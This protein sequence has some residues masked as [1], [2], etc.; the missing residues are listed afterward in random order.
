MPMCKCLCL[1]PP[2][3]EAA[4]G[5]GVFCVG[6]PQV[7]RGTCLLLCFTAVLWYGGKLWGLHSLHQIRIQMV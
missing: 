5:K 2:S 3:A 4:I 7:T 1:L 6:A